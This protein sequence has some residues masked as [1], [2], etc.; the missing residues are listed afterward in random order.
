MPD[1][2]DKP[3]I[4]LS[5]DLASRWIPIERVLGFASSDG[6]ITY[7]AFYDFLAQSGL[8]HDHDAETIF[9]ILDTDRKGY[10]DKDTVLKV[11]KDKE[12]GPQWGEFKRSIKTKGPG[13]SS[14]ITRYKTEGS[15]IVGLVAHNN[16]KPSM[17]SFVEDNLAFFRTVKITTTGST[18]RALS[19]LGLK[20][21]RLVSSGPLGGDQ[22]IGGMI[23]QGEVAAVFFFTDP[24]TAHPHDDDIKALIRICAVHDTLMATNPSTG[25]AVVHTLQHTDYGVQTLM[26]SYRD[27]ESSVVSNYKANQAKVIADVSKKG[28]DSEPAASAPTPAPA[29][30][31]RKP[32]A[33][34]D[35]DSDDDVEFEFAD[36]NLQ[37]N[38]PPLPVPAAK[39]STKSSTK[40]STLFAPLRLDRL[41]LI[42]EDDK[43][44]DPKKSALILLGFQNEMFS[45]GGWLFGTVAEVVQHTGM[46]VKVP[47]LVDAFRSKGTK[48]IHS[49]IVLDKDETLPDPKGAFDP[50][51]GE[52][53]IGKNRD[54]VLKALFNKDT[55]NSAIV[56]LFEPKAGDL[57]LERKGYDAFEA[58]GGKDLE[59]K[60]ENLDVETVFV[61]GASLRLSVKNTVS[62]AVEAGL[63]VFVA[64]DG[65]ASESLS[66]RKVELEELG[67]SGA[68]VCSCAQVENMLMH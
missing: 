14:V 17:M 45:P 28:S 49:T 35:D 9:N 38:L 50:F 58:A 6:R 24:L 19:T 32:P 43:S 63:Q 29:A 21:D 54:A 56:P 40:G 66:G 5:V 44:F 59:T 67:K 36:D 22:E 12:S 64:S 48:I 1:L 60:L 61:F 62:S 23:S 39:T 27:L 30:P 2:K 33:T 16:M 55:W 31:V 11:W 65:C 7:D 10:L 68:T 13:K 20:V 4:K 53:P 15:L 26:G 3:L 34:M 37:A 18:G 52:N 25:Y 46:L 47:E 51:N 8:T 42:M 57:I 41:S